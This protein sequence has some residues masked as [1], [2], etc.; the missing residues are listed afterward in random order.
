MGFENYK[1][2]KEC[3]RWSLNMLPYVLTPLIRITTSSFD[4]Y[5]KNI[6]YIT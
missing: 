4:I 5:V 3:L 2:K 1:K 6:L